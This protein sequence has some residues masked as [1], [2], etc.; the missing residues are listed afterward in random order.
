MSK[1]FSFGNAW[2]SMPNSIYDLENKPP[3]HFQIYDV[4]LKFFADKSAVED[5]LDKYTS[6]IVFNKDGYKVYSKEDNYD[7]LVKTGVCLWIGPFLDDR[8]IIAVIV[9]FLKRTLIAFQ[10]Y[11]DLK[12]PDFDRD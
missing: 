3:E 6:F 4:I 10:E 11:S 1:N 12:Y 5:V 9:E 8:D 2:E 7:K